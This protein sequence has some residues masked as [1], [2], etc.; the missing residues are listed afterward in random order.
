MS[1]EPD[2]VLDEE[3]LRWI[4]NLGREPGKLLEE[5]IGLFLAEAPDLMGAI[6]TALASGDPQDLAGAAHRLKGAAAH[7]GARRLYRVAA[8]A[9]ADAR[10]RTPQEAAR[11]SAT[12]H[13][14][15]DV[16]LHALK[17]LVA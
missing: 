17:R 14:E 6:D 15:L 12:V 8:E 16:T 11:T 4:R 5:M 9:E 2:A 3:V 10:A 7:I 1:A 13:E